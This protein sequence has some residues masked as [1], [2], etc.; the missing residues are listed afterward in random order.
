MKKLSLLLVTLLVAFAG[1]KKDNV[2]NAIDNKSIL[3]YIKAN[4]LTAKSTGSGLYYVVT[5][6]GDATRAISTST[7]YVKYR[8]YLLD[9]TQFDSS[10]ELSEQPAQLTISTL[11]PGFQEGLKLFGQGGKGILLIPSSLAY[12]DVVYDAIPANSV[13]IFNFEL[14]KIE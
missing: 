2:Q 14:V 12:K 8:G 10:Y 1:C 3:A 11:I 6:P 7:V 9:G 4:N 13:L 5:A